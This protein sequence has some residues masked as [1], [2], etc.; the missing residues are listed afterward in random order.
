MHTIMHDEGEDWSVCYY[1]PCEEVWRVVAYARTAERAARVCSWLN[2]G[3]TPLPVVL[4][5]IEWRR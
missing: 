1:D 4:E 3:A 5:N 2:G